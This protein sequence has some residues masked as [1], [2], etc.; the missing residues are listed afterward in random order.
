MSS[1]LTA[2]ALLFVSFAV[3]RLL[4]ADCFLSFFLSVLSYPCL[5]QLLLCCFVR[6]PTCFG[7]SYTL[8]TT[9]YT[10]YAIALLSFAST[11]NTQLSTCVCVAV[12]LDTD[13]LIS[14]SPSLSPSLLGHPTTR[15]APL[16]TRTCIRTRTRTRT[17]P[18]P[19]AKSQEPRATCGG[20]LVVACVC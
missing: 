1:N 7:Q 3:R 20:S 13:R 10:L 18:E 11:L 17:R 15:T 12:R 14:C 5:R 16:T 19:R 2:V 4:T 8:H 6:C 9:H